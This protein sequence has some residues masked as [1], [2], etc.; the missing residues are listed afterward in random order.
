MNK[1]IIETQKAPP[2]IGPY[3]QAVFAGNVLYVSGQIAMDPQSGDIIRDSLEKETQLV[4]R[5]MQNILEKAGLSMENVVK[6]SIFLKDMEDFKIVN[7]VYSLYFK[8]NP[9]A[10]ETVAVSQLPKAVNVEISCIAHK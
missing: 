4:M 7:E 1:K 2:P 3:S 6:C 8:E 10:R 5:N 9:P